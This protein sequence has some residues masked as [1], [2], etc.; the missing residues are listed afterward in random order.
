MRDSFI[1]GAGMIPM[2]RHRESSYPGLAVPAVLD[3]LESA[4]LR[5]AEIG[6]V[7]C[8]HAFGGMLTGQRIVKEI[9]IGGIPVT[10]VDNACSGGATAL[11]EAHRA[12]ADGHH[13]V[14]LVIGVDKL[15]QFGGGTLPLV[16][17]DW[18]VQQ[19][20]VM[21]ALYAMRAR[22]YLHERDASVED[23]ASVSVKARRH[24]VA[25]PYAQ[26][27]AEVTVE[28][29]LA[30]RP[31]ADPLTL[32]QCCPTGDGAAAVL[33]V[34]DAVRRRLGGPALR[35]A[36]SVLHSGQVIGGFRDMLRP[37]ITFESA[38][39][40]YEQAG[41][42]PRDIDVVEL[43]DAFSIAELVYYEALGLCPVGES[44]GFLRS[45]A[46]TYGGEVVVNPS[47][48]LLAKGHPVGASGVAQVVEVFWHLTGTA[49]TRQVDGARLG[50]THVTGGGIS[51][52]DHGACTVHIFEHV[53]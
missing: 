36:A 22:R 31:I 38:R 1:V 28:Q 44:T 20:M 6:A 7:Y 29:V 3:A 5:R 9:G 13:E 51:G 18:E 14:V 43:H 8:G 12:V 10:N 45:G 2:G 21:P 26:F 40:A 30:A 42:S 41:V 35:I 34:S 50:L 53:G 17:E 25:N 32:L 47:G 19:G 46:T 4:G 15:T 37:E 23:L 27:R 33:V 39:E 49:G 48:G 52:L 16:T 11:H 24:G